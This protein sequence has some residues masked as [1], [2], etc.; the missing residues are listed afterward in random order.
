MTQDKS[1]SDKRCV[2][3]DLRWPKGQSVNSGSNFDKYLDT[4]STYPSIDNITDQVLLLGRGCQIFKVDISRAFRH[5]GLYWDHY[6]INFFADFLHELGLTVS[7]SKLVPPGTKVVCLGILV[8]TE[9]CS[10]SILPQKLAVIKDLCF[11]WST[12]TSCMK[13]RIAVT[14]RVLTVWGQMY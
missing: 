14:S 9:D 1:S 13:K 10:V 11:Q 7:Q 2:I 12:K 8:N 5:L 4:V 3:I 6:Y